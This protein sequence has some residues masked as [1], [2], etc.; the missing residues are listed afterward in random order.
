M[1]NHHNG[2]MVCVCNKR[3]V[4]HHETITLFLNACH[5][6][7][8]QRTGMS[9][10]LYLMTIIQQCVDLILMQCSFCSFLVIILH[11][12][13]LTVMNNSSLISLIFLQEYKSSP[14]IP[15]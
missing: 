15:S 1:K 4:L 8:S 3:N 7:L 5:I 2:W 12:L 10:I 9:T 11:C 6:L 14:L 13:I